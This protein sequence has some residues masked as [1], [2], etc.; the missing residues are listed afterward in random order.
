MTN[1]TD[2]KRSIINSNK[3]LAHRG[4]DDEGFVCIN[5][6]N[7]S[8][9]EYSGD[10]SIDYFKKTLPNITTANYSNFDLV[11]GHRRLSIIDLSKNGHCPMSDEEGKI[12][13]TFNGEIYNYIELRKEL[14]SY[15]YH[16]KTKSDT[17]VI[18]KAYQK[19]G[20]EC[21][22]HFNGMWAF[23]IWD[24][25]TRELLLSRDRFGIKPL[26]Y[27][28][29]ENFFAFSSE[30]KPLLNIIPRDNSINLKLI[31]FFIL[32][33]NR[34]NQEDTY[35]NKIK[36]L[37]ASHYLIHKKNSVETKRYYKIPVKTTNTKTESTLKEELLEIFTD[38]IKLRFRSDV[39]VGTC[40]SGGFDS[41]GI[42]A[43]SH[44]IFGDGLNTFS[45]VW[46]D[47]DC[48]ESKYIDIV[49]SK[50]GCI[51]N[52]IEPSADEFEIV[53]EKLCYYQEMPTEGPGLYPQWYVMQKAK[54][55]VKVLLDGQGGDEVF[56]GY[57]NYGNYLRSL[58]KDKRLKDI[59]THRSLYFTLF[60]NNG[61]LGF[62]NWLFPNFYNKYFKLNFSRKTKVLSSELLSRVKRKD[63]YLDFSPPK[64]FDN[65]LNNLSN[66]FLTSLTIPALLHY[67]D[68]SSMAHSIESRVPFL[69]YRLVEFGI[70]LHP[71]HLAENNF[72]RP[73][74]RKAFKNIL[75]RQITERKDK[76][77]YPAPFDKW[78]RNNIKE[79]VMD[80][81]DDPNALIF[82][83]I[84]KKYLDENLSRHFKK[85]INYGW[86]IWRLLS[87]EKFL[88]LVNNTQSAFKSQG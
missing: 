79:Y 43:I 15:G 8:F 6:V 2:I 26:Y 67:E 12:W 28:S 50:Y 58:I 19:W 3:L 80:I 44:K 16:F 38:S 9:S 61:T 37:N 64:I 83:Y 31:P 86:Y 14:E 81:F 74:Y 70:N 51:P 34:F 68:R 39:K 56:G 46:S 40:L 85:E 53:F 84:N 49:N 62:S 36:S 42:V 88:M 23:A 35:V 11:L 72:T 69:D 18:I 57:F 4:P 52:K 5:T 73:L 33:G 41:S 82:S 27:I 63:L 29:D 71:N 54:G 7:T 13:I 17:E 48:D 20:Y 65:Y 87:F 25:N 77:G 1:D 45:A 78:T 60:K 24:S 55:K 32:Y 10:E 66:H 22:N 75:P 76:L 30:I 59:I 47:K 21:F